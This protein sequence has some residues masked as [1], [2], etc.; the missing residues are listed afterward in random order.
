M[1]C[2]D[3][4]CVSRNPGM[5][6]EAK[7]DDYCNICYM[8][9][10]S[11]APCI[12]LDCKHIYHEEC[13]V[14]VLSGKWSGPRINFQYL[15]C[16]N[17]KIGMEC[18]HQEASRLIREGRMLEETIKKMAIKRGKHE[19]ID[20]DKRMMEPPYNGKLEPYALARLSYYMCFKCKKPY[21]GGLKS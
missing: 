20:K 3:E 16:P 1:P 13:I 8:S 2:L 19:G 12:Q 5:T 11:Q 4:D 14:R 9:G 10:L 18:F 21:F 15:N 6:L 17:C 7:G